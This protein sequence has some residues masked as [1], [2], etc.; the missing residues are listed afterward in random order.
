MVFVYSF[1]NEMPHKNAEIC[2]WYLKHTFN[3]KRT[4]SCESSM[5]ISKIRCQKEKINTQAKVS[6]QCQALE[7]CF[8]RREYE[9]F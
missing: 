6:D 3:F 7:C 4:G 9:K 8:T 2:R 5:M 1:C